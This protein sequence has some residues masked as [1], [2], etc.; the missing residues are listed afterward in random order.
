MKADDHKRPDRSQLPWSA[1][2]DQ[3]LHCPIPATYLAHG[4]LR[5][6]SA[7]S[8][9]DRRRKLRI[10]YCPGYANAFLPIGGKLPGRRRH[11]V[12]DFPG[13]DWTLKLSELRDILGIGESAVWRLRK[14]AGERPVRRGRR[15]YSYSDYPGADWTASAKDIGEVTGLSRKSVYKLRE[16]WELATLGH[17]QSRKRDRH[18]R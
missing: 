7:G 10:Y 9:R 13:V 1:T 6:R 3:F 8:V 14:E 2:E 5:G 11:V 12:D 16:E 17:V 4:A 18:R 15:A